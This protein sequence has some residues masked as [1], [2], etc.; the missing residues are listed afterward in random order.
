VGHVFNPPE[1]PG[2]Q[3]KNMPHIIGQI[4]LYVAFIYKRAI[5]GQMAAHLQ[6]QPLFSGPKI[7][8]RT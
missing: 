1:L 4:L 8:S 5:F 6:L 3:V 7:D 2:R